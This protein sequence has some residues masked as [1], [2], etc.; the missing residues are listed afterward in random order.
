MKQITVILFFVLVFTL[1]GCNNNE[2]YTKDE[3]DTIMI[4]TVRYNQDVLFYKC[5]SYDFDNC[6]LILNVKD[7]ENDVYSLLL[8]I[9]ELEQRIE[10]LETE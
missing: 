5:D 2:Y 9:Q 8:K 4:D 7:T 1:S 6:T 3:I 10:Q